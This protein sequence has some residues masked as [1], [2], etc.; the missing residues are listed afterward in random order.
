MKHGV[1][2]RKQNRSHRHRLI[3]GQRLDTIYKASYQQ[4]VQ[5]SP[6]IGLLV[7]FFYMATMKYGN[8]GFKCV[9]LCPLAC[10]HL[11]GTLHISTKFC[12]KHIQVFPTL[13][14]PQK[15]PSILCYNKFSSLFSYMETFSIWCTIGQTP[16]PCV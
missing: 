7:F 3:T 13:Q 12:T 14:N 2:L 10:L 9:K 15:R 1:P 11:L 6:R 8:P 4:I 5:K 16:P